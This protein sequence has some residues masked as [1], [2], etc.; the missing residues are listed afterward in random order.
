MERFVLNILND[1]DGT[2][3]GKWQPTTTI[4]EIL[5]A[6][7]TS[8]N[9]PNPNCPARADIHE[10]FVKNRGTRSN[11]KAWPAGTHYW[12]SHVDGMQSAKGLRGAFIYLQEYD[13]IFAHIKKNKKYE[14][15]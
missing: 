7:Q 10:M 6:V 3:H 2:W 8:L 13:R 5:L 11:F 9:E 4:P 12:H 14:L 1:N 15:C